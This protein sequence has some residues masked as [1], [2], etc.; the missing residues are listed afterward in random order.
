M[1]QF[2]NGP[3]KGTTLML[4]KSPR[5]LRVTEENGKFDALDQPTDTPSP[6]EKIYVYER[7]G[8]PGAVHINAKK[9]G[10][11]YSMATYRY[12]ENQPTDEYMRD[13]AKWEYWRNYAEG[14]FEE[15]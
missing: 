9:G 12:F 3:A 10:G 13:A 6:T 14:Y 4:K 7:V 11:F 5:F 2:E 8:D 1:T 15:V